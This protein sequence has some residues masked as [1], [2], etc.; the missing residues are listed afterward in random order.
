[1]LLGSQNITAGDKRRY[2]VDYGEFL[3]KGA[4]LTAVTVTVSAGAT[5]S[6]GTGPTAPALNVDEKGIIFWLTGGTLNEKFTANIQVTDNNSEIV[7]DTIQ[8]TVV[9]P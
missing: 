8:F 6:V 3:I 5:S 1:M 4:I 9:A 7:N 2:F